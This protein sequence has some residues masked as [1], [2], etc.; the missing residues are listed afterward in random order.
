M[1]FQL[2][3]SLALNLTGAGAQSPVQGNE[4]GHGGDTYALEFRTFGLEISSA[5]AKNRQTYIHLFQKWNFNPEGFHGAALSTQVNSDEEEKVSL[6]GNKMDEINFPAPVQHAGRIL[7]NRTRWRTSDLGPKIRIVMHAYFGILG[8]ERDHYFASDDFRGFADQLTHDLIAQIK[9][10]RSSLSLNYYGR[11]VVYPALHDREACAMAST[12]VLTGKER[13]LQEAQ[14][15]C[16]VA[17]ISDC[18]QHFFSVNTVTSREGF[19]T[20][21]CEILAVVR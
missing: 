21:A 12:N 16:R 5:L 8:V 2:F 18:N 4:G 20:R 10:K 14:G 19:G 1:I 15:R 17:G 3:L 11:Q 6:R 13:A 7:I 9:S